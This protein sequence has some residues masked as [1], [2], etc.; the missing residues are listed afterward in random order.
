MKM[1]NLLYGFMLS[2]SVMMVLTL[3]S[4]GAFAQKPTLQSEFASTRD[5]DDPMISPFSQQIAAAEP[6]LKVSSFNQTNAPNIVGIA[7]TRDERSNEK[8]NQTKKAR[9]AKQTQKP[10]I[11]TVR[12]EF[13]NSVAQKVEGKKKRVRKSRRATNVV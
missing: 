9:K 1:R 2:A 8:V 12:S 5:S 10:K 11:K 4:T 13:G 7:Q 3:T 6:E